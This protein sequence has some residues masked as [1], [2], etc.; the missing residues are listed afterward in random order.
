MYIKVWQTRVGDTIE[1]DLVDGTSRTNL[2]P[3]VLPKVGRDAVPF[4]E[5]TPMEQLTV[6]T[7][8]S[9]YPTAP[10]FIVIAEP[11]P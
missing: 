11:A 9:Y 4:L 5:P 1:L 2:V 6:Q 8:A 3:K 7:S 10:P